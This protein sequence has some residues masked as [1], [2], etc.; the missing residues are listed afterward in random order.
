M[1][2]TRSIQQLSKSSLRLLCPAAKT[3]AIL[4]PFVL[5]RL[6]SRLMWGHH[7]K[8]TRR[9][10]WI[11]LNDFENLTFLS[12]EEIPWF[13]EEYACHRVLLVS[14]PSH[15]CR[16]IPRHMRICLKKTHGSTL[17]FELSSVDYKYEQR[18]DDHVGHAEFSPEKGSTNW[19]TIGIGPWRT[20]KRIFSSDQKRAERSNDQKRSEKKLGSPPPCL[21]LIGLLKM[22]SRLMFGLC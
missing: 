13:L 12:S 7:C 8:V 14:V 18:S 21:F 6:R 20:T 15:S 5:S 22:I 11:Y 19:P 2:R 9:H 3:E 17:A 4:I 16:D 1:A 10:G